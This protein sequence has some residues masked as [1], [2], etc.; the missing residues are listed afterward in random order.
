[1]KKLLGLAFVA[2]FMMSMSSVN[3][4]EKE[5]DCMDDVIIFVTQA[6]NSGQFDESELAWW[7]NGA[8]AVYCYGYTWEDVFY[9]P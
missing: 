6:A 9:A 7:T 1:M 4:I 5:K 8:Y 3:I 2:I